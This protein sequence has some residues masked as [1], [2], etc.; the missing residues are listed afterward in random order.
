MLASVETRQTT[1]GCVPALLEE[2]PVLISVAPDYA[3]LA[4]GIRAAQARELSI[5]FAG[6]EHL[7]MEFLELA[8]ELTSQADALR[9]EESLT[10]QNGPDARTGSVPEIS[11]EIPFKL[12]ADLEYALVRLAR[13]VT[14]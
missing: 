7:H 4:V 5:L 3:K 6:D 14:K 10:G 1:D 8:A 11:I 9:R 13:D 2:L 12:P